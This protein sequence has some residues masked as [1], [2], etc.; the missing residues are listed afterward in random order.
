MARGNVATLVVDRDVVVGQIGGHAD[1]HVTNHRPFATCVKEL[2]DT[3]YGPAPMGL[4]ISSAAPSRS[5]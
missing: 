5:S 3:G 4:P 2:Q 1:G